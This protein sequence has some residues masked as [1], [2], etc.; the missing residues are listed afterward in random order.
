MAYV[1][2]RFDIQYSTKNIPVIGLF[3]YQQLL[4]FRTE[5]LLRRMRWKVYWDRNKDKVKEFESYG[6]RSPAA[7]PYCKELKAFEDDLLKM[8]GEVE[9]R[10]F[11]NELQTRMKNDLALL[12]Q[13]PDTV[14]IS[15]DKTSNFYLKLHSS[16]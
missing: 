15:S 4:T 16:N 14:V 3:K 6:F 2:R 11:N 8:I 5:D 10:P 13:M 12:R 9:T 7:A 1:P